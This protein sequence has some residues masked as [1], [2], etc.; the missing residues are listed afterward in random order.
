MVMCVG[1]DRTNARIVFSTGAGRVCPGCGWPAR[2]CRCSKGG[3]DQPVPDRIVARL[4]V[5]KAGRGGKTVT[6]VYGLP[7]NAVFLKELC[8]ELKRTCG[9]G[10]AV[11]EDTVELQGDHRERIRDLLLKK[12]FLVKG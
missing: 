11:A 8:K 5:E 9:T 3:A 1:S 12:G 10:G 7:R 4:R 6:V 2:D